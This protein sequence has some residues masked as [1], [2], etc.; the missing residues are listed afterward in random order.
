MRSAIDE[1]GLDPELVEGLL[2]AEL[3]EALFEEEVVFDIVI[4]RS[5]LY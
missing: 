4:H 1:A 2:R 3:A 5:F